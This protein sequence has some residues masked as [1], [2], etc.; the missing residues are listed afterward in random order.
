MIFNV[1]TKDNKK[2]ITHYSAARKFLKEF[3]KQWI[4]QAV[5]SCFIIF[6]K[7]YIKFLY[8]KIAPLGW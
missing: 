4:I 1:R 3:Q 5:I 8:V 2:A 7:H 6:E